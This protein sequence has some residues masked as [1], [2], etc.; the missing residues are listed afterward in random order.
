MYG[1]VPV[2]FMGRWQCNESLGALGEQG[3]TTVPLSRIPGIDLHGRALGVVCM[4]G[5]WQ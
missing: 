5:F 3:G 1:R 4:G 2:I